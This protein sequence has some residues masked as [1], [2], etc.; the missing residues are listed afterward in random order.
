MSES[1]SEI[2]LS[3][4]KEAGRP[5]R[6]R[7]IWDRRPESWEDA[8]PSHI[9]GILCYLRDRGDAVVH[10]DESGMNIWSPTASGAAASAAPKHKEPVPPAEPP[11]E[12]DPVIVSIAMI[13]RL[14]FEDADVDARRLR[15][16]ARTEVL[17]PTVNGFL[18]A[19]AEKLEKMVAA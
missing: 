13:Q 16:L 8:T 9:A 2:V 11:S 15:A 10:K 5:L 19:L 4:L 6:G 7:E 12:E 17:P 18:V 14:G 1:K 3:I